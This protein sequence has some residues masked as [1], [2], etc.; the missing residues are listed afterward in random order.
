MIPVVW[1][2]A[3]EADL[4]EIVDFIALDNLK[5]AMELARRI[6]SAIE[7]NLP[8]T[9]HIGRPGR[10]ANTRE[11]IVHKNYLVIYRVTDTSVDILS[12]RHTAQLFPNSH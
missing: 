9:P 7:D 2:L 12:V 5:A 10:V 4:E 3:S 6:V 1:S 8:A 11:L